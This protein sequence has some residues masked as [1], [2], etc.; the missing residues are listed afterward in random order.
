[1]A[2]K[3]S[4]TSTKTKNKNKSSKSKSNKSSNA[5]STLTNILATELVALEGLQGQHPETGA[6]LN[7]KNGKINSYVD[8]YTNRVFGAPY[9][10]LDTVDRRFDSVNKH[11]GNEYLR[12]IILNSP[13]LH[14]KP[15]M[16]YYTGGADEKS[17]VK[18]LKYLYTGSGDNGAGLTKVQNL[19]T[20]LAKSTVFSKGSKLQKRMFGF[21]ENYYQYMC[22]VNYMCRSTA[23]FLNLTSSNSGFPNGIRIGAK[24]YEFATMDWS[25]Y[26]FISNTKVTSPM[27]QLKKM[28]KYSLVGKATG[29]AKKS[30]NSIKKSLSNKKK[31]GSKTVTNSLVKKLYGS[32]SDS[33][34]ILG[35][36]KNNTNKESNDEV[37][38][39]TK[40]NLS[41]VISNKVCS[42]LFMVEPVM[43]EDTLTNN[44]K[45]SA[46]ESA[47]DSVHSAVGS[48]L[49]FITGSNADTGLIG[50]I[51]EFLG[52]TVET[53]AEFVSGLTEP[54][55][56]GFTSNLFNGALKSIKG[57]KMIYPKI[58]DTSNSETNYTFTVNLST[59]YGDA[60]NYYLNI[61]VPL[62]H[63]I[64]LAAPRMVTANSVNSPYLVQAFIPGMCTCQLGIISN[65][66]IQKNPNANHVSVN[67]FPLD[68]K[69]TFTVQELY[70]ALSISPTNDPASFLFNETLNDYMSNLAGLQPCTNTYDQQRLNAFKNLETYFTKDEWAQD[71]A[72]D[73]LMKMEDF[74]SPY[75]GR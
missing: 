1:M 28:A 15:G 73:A 24:D 64:A 5:K 58:Y 66:S 7:K 40:T 32:A 30:L 38:L 47:I 67:G 50:D 11:V 68:V 57:Q 6:G 21:R 2:K 43:F 56:G 49:A 41:D 70:N 26:R 23:V 3:K 22:H 42:V 9:Q 52:S 34:N 63:L 17:I 55:T 69:V 74:I 12:N 65:M 13:I 53:A 20:S 61:L 72:N 10:F 29:S 51:T 59:P 8:K 14:I 35:T 31:K 4:T 36:N 48:E 45:D 62:F 60:Y 39:S 19:L 27:S 16:P 18:T 37:T 44:T 33:S 75:Q 71:M 46:I 25:K 54:L